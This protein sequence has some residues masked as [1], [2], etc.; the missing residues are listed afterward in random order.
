VKNKKKDAI[1]SLKTLAVRVK[2]LTSETFNSKKFC[3]T[4]TGTPNE[5]INNNYSFKKI[6]LLPFFLRLTM[7]AAWFRIT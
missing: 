7:N 6:L 4:N 3:K 2:S 5:K 1:F